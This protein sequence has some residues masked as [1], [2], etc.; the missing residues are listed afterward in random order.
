MPA[1]HYAASPRPYVGLPPLDYSFQDWTATVTHGGRV[2]FRQRKI[3]VS[4][5]LAG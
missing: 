1:A 4:Y 3:N 5:A 2:C